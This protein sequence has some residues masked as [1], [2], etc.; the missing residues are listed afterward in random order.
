MLIWTKLALCAAIVLSTAATASA[1]TKKR[2]TTAPSQRLTRSDV[3]S[4]P[5]PACR[6]IHSCSHRRWYPW[7]QSY[8]R[9]L[10]TKKLRK[11]TSLMF[12]TPAGSKKGTSM[13]VHNARWPQRNFADV[14]NAALP[15][16]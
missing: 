15:T 4:A 12:A 14:H 10:L 5:S 11:R 3:R 6:P 7:L 1:A 2:K 13:T 9:A 8:A 16:I